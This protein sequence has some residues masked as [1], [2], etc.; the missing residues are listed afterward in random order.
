MIRKTI[1]LLLFFLLMASQIL[2]AQDNSEITNIIK[3]KEPIEIISDRMEAFNEEKM[4]V[5]SGNASAKKGDIVLK[6]DQLF[7]YYKN[8]P[9]KI[10]KIGT[11]GIGDS[12]ELDRIEAKGNVIVTQGRNLITG[13]KVVIYINEDRGSVVPCTTGNNERVKAIIYHQ[14]K[15]EGEK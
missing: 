14:E 4:V 3:N 5:F 10:D 9:D 12:A 8:G 2:Y 15:K 6:A 11:K 13:C 1:Y 7:I